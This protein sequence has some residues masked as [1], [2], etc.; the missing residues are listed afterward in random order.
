MQDWLVSCRSCL[1]GLY[2]NFLKQR[3]RAYPFSFRFSRFPDHELFNIPQRLHYPARLYFLA[4]QRLSV[5]VGMEEDVCYYVNKLLFFI[6]LS[7]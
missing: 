5:G 3:Q 2:L 6:T 7:D 1:S 4:D